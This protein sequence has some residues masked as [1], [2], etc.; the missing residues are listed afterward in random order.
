[1]N[2]KLLKGIRVSQGYTQKPVADAAGMDVSTYSEKENGKRQF[3]PDEI[4]KIA[5]FLGMDLYQVNEVFF[6]KKL[7]N[8]SRNELSITSE[9]RKSA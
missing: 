4:E 8:R 2:G 7:T 9:T 1:M 5:A 3:T 6:D